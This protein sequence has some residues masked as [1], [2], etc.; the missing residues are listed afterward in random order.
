MILHWPWFVYLCGCGLAAILAFFLD[1]W[2]IIR[3]LRRDRD[4][5]RRKT[6]VA[7]GHLGEVEMAIESRCTHFDSNIAW[8]RLHDGVAEC[9]SC[10]VQGHDA[11]GGER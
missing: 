11:V 1:W 10:F 6:E 4:R 9:A 7:Y 5:W 8:C 3:P 2:F